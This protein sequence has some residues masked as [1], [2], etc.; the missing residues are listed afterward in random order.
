MGFAKRLAVLVLAFVLCGTAGAAVA[1]PKLLLSGN[2]LAGAK[3]V[4]VGGTA[5]DV[6]FEDGTCFGLFSGCVN[7]AFAFNTYAQADAASHA[8]AD[9]V[10][11]NVDLGN[12]DTL[13]GLTTGCTSGL[14]CRVLTFYKSSGSSAYYASVDNDPG[15]GSTFKTP[16][17]F[18]VPNGYS[19]G[20]AMT[21]AV[22]RVSP[23]PE[24]ETYAMLLA[25]L[26]LMGAAVKRRKK[27]GAV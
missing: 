7:S 15:I 1:A 20:T 25:G 10:F 9:Q 16:E 11:K 5:Y 4:M 21:V 3:N 26:G 14:S 6:T 2:Q 19:A 22:W 12:F 8:L 24:P 17:G 27:A 23:T 18:S 13:P